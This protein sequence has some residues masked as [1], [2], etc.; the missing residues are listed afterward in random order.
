MDTLNTSLNTSKEELIDGFKERFAALAPQ[1]TERDK[2][3]I[4][5]KSYRSIYMVKTYLNGE[6]Y[7][8]LAAGKFLEEAERI[9]AGKAVA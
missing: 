8:P 3:D 7:D 6:I 4:A 9:I 1:L 2:M 5:M